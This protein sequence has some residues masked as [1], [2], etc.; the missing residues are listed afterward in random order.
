[1]Q[2]NQTL[3]FSVKFKDLKSGNETIFDNNR[4]GFEIKN[5][6]DYIEL[7]DIPVTIRYSDFNKM[8]K[9]ALTII[10]QYAEEPAEITVVSFDEKYHKTLTLSGL[11]DYN[12]VGVFRLYF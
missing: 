10:I 1:M 12:D 9:G 4:K 8:F 7:G 11:P 5:N 6:I 2:N 3:K